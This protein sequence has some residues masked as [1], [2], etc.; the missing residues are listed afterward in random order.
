MASRPR[1]TR[2]LSLTTRLLT[3][4]ATSLRVLSQELGLVVSCQLSVVSC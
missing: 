2:S 3:A 1:V 4:I